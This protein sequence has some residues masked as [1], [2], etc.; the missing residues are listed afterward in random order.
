MRIHWFSPLPYAHTDIADYTRRLLLAL[1][2]RA[3]VILWT[4]QE[5]WAYRLKFE[6]E[7]RRFDPLALPRDLHDGAVFYNIGNNSQFHAAI[8]EAARRVPGFAILHD[9]F[10][11]DSLAHSYQIRQDR[12]G[13]FQ[14]MQSL[15]GARGRRDAELYWNHALAM[16]QIGRRYTCA[17]H[18]LQGSLGAI[19]HSH[20]AARTLRRET[21]LPVFELPLP[22]PAR[23]K[24]GTHIG[25]PPWKLIV[26][27]Y[28]GT[29]RC[30]DQILTALAGV[31][32]RDSF[33]LHIYGK[34]ENPAPVA[35]L[36][37]RL[38]LQELV[39][40]RGFVPARQLERAL[41]AAHLAINLRF[42]TKGEASG[43]QLRI[44]SHALPS[45]VSRIGW[46]AE[47]PEDT[48]AF[49]RPRYLVEDLRAHLAQYAASPQRYIDA[50]L[51]GHRYFVE[52]HSPEKYA[53]AIVEL[54]GRAAEYRRQANAALLAGR[55]TDAL[56]GWFDPAVFPDYADRIASLA[57]E[58]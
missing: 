8:W 10:L 26:F 43:S 24:L 35:A 48:A 17:P 49:V 14:T 16:P 50:G 25:P 36:I 9:V 22:F 56:A 11:H 2:S 12:S 6:A 5:R 18:I 19:V 4:N 52:R 40:I 55:A 3:D 32:E 51:A 47:L 53:D 33:R 45:I 37:E 30:I 23:R 57:S 54:A 28:L 41:A 34:L 21:R 39:T 1:C 20:M 42:P 7:V 46:Y 29:N 13:Y 31:P 58:M 27:G 38:Q 15:Y 44:W